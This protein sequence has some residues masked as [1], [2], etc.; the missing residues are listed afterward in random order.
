MSS[1]TVRK[2]TLVY[3]AINAANHSKEIWGEDALEFKPERWKNGKAISATTR[4]CGIY[5]NTMTFIGGGRS[6]M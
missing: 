6:C 1:I 4:M 3:I 2:G 5:G